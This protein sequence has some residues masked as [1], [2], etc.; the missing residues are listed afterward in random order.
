VVDPGRARRVLEALASYRNRLA[1]LRDLPLEEYLAQQ[2]FA[3][4]YLVQVSAQ[5]CIDLA[6]HVIASSGWRAPRDF[7][8]M[9]TVL[10]ENGVVDPDLGERLRALAG[11]RNRLVHLYEDVDDSLVYRA[12]DSGLS[13]LDAFGQ[14][15]ARLLDDDSS[16]R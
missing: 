10:E 13:D 9:F 4:R 11:L 5:T 8:D 1:S 3:G 16:G 7:R 2:A 6:N 15:I 12:L 14:A